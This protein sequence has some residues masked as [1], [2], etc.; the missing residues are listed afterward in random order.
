MM[1]G[2]WLLRA[3]S[4]L[5]T[6]LVIALVVVALLPGSLER[7]AAQALNAAGFADAGLKLA[8]LDYDRIVVT[9]L[10]LGP[11]AQLSADRI[12]AAI[13][14]P[15]LLALRIGDLIVTA[16]NLELAYDGKR[17]SLR[18]MEHLF[19]LEL[20]GRREFATKETREPVALT[21]SGIADWPIDRVA[22]QDARLA[23]ALPNDT[24]SAELSAKV[25]RDDGGGIALR[26]DRL[27]LAHPEVRLSARLGGSLDQRGNGR[28][29]LEIL[30]GLLS[31]AGLVLALEHA[32]FVAAGSA[33]NVRALNLESSA[34]GSLSESGSGL[35]ATLQ[36][37]ANLHDDRL[38]L[39]L[40]LAEPGRDSELEATVRAPDLFAAELRAALSVRLASDDLSRLARISPHLQG[41]DGRGQLAVELETS[42]AGLLRA[43][44][45][46]Q[47]AEP[48]YAAALGALQQIAPIELAAKATK[49]TWQ[50]LPAAFDLD[51]ALRLQATPD[52]LEVVLLQVLELAEEEREKNAWANR[53]AALLGEAP[54]GFGKRLRL[55][56]D[57]P[58]VPLV[59]LNT[60]D[61]EFVISSTAR[62]SLEALLPTPIKLRLT[63]ALAYDPRAGEI[64]RWELREFALLEALP[65]QFAAFE[66][67][68][69]KLEGH[70]A[71]A[72][73]LVSA[74]VDLRAGAVGTIAS[75]VT[76]QQ[77][78]LGARANLS[79][80]GTELKVMPEGCITIAPLR[81]GAHRRG[82]WCRKRADL[83]C[84]P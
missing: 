23:L 41:L 21:W 30:H 33:E 10:R 42:L 13:A 12:E 65:L 3:A 63:G 8:Q 16:P 66:L 68:L 59:S 27:E 45:Q 5:L 80:D 6:Y 19:N 7:L 36:V 84:R 26:V 31:R 62:F 35:A 67:T 78:S 39:H 77:V 83:H 69:P 79:F 49:L 14:W 76:V 24:V 46:V 43:F 55:V 64:G 56:L 53:V 71:E 18:G 1:L 32:R 47:R 72:D 29:E 58:D 54:K 4:R 17:L 61:D 40:S 81:A 60:G 37:E 73:G 25:A 52:G 44:E 9:D 74:H 11:V 22:V 75:D 15:S 82:H 51:V 34:N 70:V 2:L 28:L 48:D 57:E 50:A 38:A 20:G